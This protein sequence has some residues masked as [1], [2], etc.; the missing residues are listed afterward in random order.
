MIP[1]QRA[2]RTAASNAPTSA[3]ALASTSPLDQRREARRVAVVAQS[4]GVNGRWD[5]VVAEGVH[6]HQ[7]GHPDGVA[8]VVGVTA[9]GQCRARRGLGRHEPSLDA[10][11][12][13][14]PKERIG[15]AGEVRAASDA[16]DH[17][18]R[19]L[20]RQLHLL[21]ALTDDHGLVQA[22]SG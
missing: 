22:D 19:G 2:K 21:D 4:A 15:D 1:S 11:A 12:N 17:H 5:E 20:S 9:A 7:R 16:A 10:L 18:V 13:P 8:E 6:R 14:P 3:I